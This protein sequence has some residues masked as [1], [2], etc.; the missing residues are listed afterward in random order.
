M[1]IRNLISNII[2]GFIPG[3]SRRDLVRVKIRYNTRAYVKFVRDY[4]GDGSLPIKTCV[5]YGCSNFIVLA[6]GRYAFKFPLND[7][8]A[9]RALRE[10]RITTALRKYTTF[11]IPQ[12]EIIKWNNIAVRKYEFF[13]GVTLSEIPPRI[14]LAN[15]HHIARQIALFVYQIGMAG[16]SAIGCT[17]ID[18]TSPIFDLRADRNHRLCHFRGNGLGQKESG[19]VWGGAAGPAHRLWGRHFAG[20][21]AG[22]DPA[23]VFYQVLDAAGRHGGGADGVFCGPELKGPVFFQRSCH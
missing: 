9:A 3:K 13:P 2:C 10:L 22:P 11:K 8:G 4:L 14:A 15:R 12:M 20:L 19:P 17:I 16:Q 1:K 5:G 21:P 18:C 6:G 7:D 23:P